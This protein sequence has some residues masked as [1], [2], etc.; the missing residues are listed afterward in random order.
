M[1]TENEFLNFLLEN[2]I[3]VKIDV[4]NKKNKFQ[5]VQNLSSLKDKNSIK[6]EDC[7]IYPAA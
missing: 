6:L 2:K 4:Y 5:R 3:N 7:F 1:L